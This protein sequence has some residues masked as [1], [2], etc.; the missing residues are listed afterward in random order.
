MAYFEITGWDD[1]GNPT[2]VN[3]DDGF[4]Q[5]SRRFEAERDGWMVH[6]L[7]PADFLGV[8]LGRQ[9]EA[10]IDEVNRLRRENFELKKNY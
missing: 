2:H 4:V 6:Q 7:N 1:Q 10:L 8:K 5:T 9:T 3:L